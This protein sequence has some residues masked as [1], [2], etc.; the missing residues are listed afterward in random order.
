M[1]RP[2]APYTKC[3]CTLPLQAANP[4]LIISYCLPVLPEG[5]THNGV[6]LLANAVKWGVKID[7]LQLMAMDYGGSAAP[8]PAGK[9]GY[10]AIQVGAGGVGGG[11]Q[12]TRLC[13]GRVGARGGWCMEG[14]SPPLG[15]EQL[16]TQP[17]L[18]PVQA[19][20]NSRNQALSVGMTN[21]KIG[22]IPMIGVNDV[23]EEV[24]TLEDAC[25]VCC[26]WNG[27]IFRPAGRSAEYY[28]LL[29]S[30]WRAGGTRSQGHGG[31]IAGCRQALSVI[32]CA[33]GGL[34]HTPGR[35]PTHLTHQ[36]EPQTL[37]PKP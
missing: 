28:S 30:S 5:L 31:S 27:R 6:A 10:Y 26:A 25:Q 9:M 23:M 1:A 33:L 22:L 15:R 7:T 3:V 19:A 34:R 20:I 8:N 21:T 18:C 29:D 17:V 12:R 4:D 24:F 16:F 2:S 32:G 35:A 36:H 37:N 14:S 13:V 11:G